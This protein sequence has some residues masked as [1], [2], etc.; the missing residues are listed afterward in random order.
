[1]TRYSRR[2]AASAADIAVTLEPE[3]ADEVRGTVLAGL[4]AHN[5]IHA[6]APD[7]Q[8]LVLAARDGDGEI[9]GALAG[10]TAWQWLHVVSLWVR[11][12]RLS[13][14]AVL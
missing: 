8:P 4:R 3:P 7:F 13:G 6:E 9:V 5:R 14:A 10:E 11:H 1:M 12:A 2:A